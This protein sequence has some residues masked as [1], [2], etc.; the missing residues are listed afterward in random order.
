[1]PPRKLTLTIL[2][3]RFAICRLPAT[4]PI[5]DWATRGQIFSVTRTDEELSITCEESAAPPG[6]LD[7]SLP[8]L[9]V[10]KDWRALKFEGPFDFSE[11]GV[12][13]SVVGPLA[14]AGISLFAVSTYDTDYLLLREPDFERA[15]QVL[16]GQGHAVSPLDFFPATRK[17]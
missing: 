14:D 8:G 5:P 6:A 13:A 3:A 15:C 2:P 12:L 4:A 9:K 10:S 1:M 17:T 11:V 7:G 16:R